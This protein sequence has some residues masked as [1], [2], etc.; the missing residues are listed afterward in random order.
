M[1]STLSSLPYLTPTATRALCLRRCDFL[2][3]CRPCN[4]WGTAHHKT[5]PE[6]FFAAVVRPG[7]SEHM[8]PE[9]R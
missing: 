1:A 5:A 7:F 8:H 3:L 4:V 9:L 6:P 2:T